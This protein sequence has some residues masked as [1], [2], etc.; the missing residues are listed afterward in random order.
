VSDEIQMMR[1]IITEA[2]NSLYGSKGFFMTLDGEKPPHKYHLAEAIEKLKAQANREYNRA[3][4]LREALEP[5]ARA[6]ELFT[7]PPTDF[8]QC[9][10]APAAGNRYALSGNDL[11][12][13]RE[14]MAY[15]QAEATK[16]E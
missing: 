14:A 16:S 1:A 10:Y 5:F 9:I 4:R 2:N 13:A 11:R 15:P 8:D 7:G 3:E 6:G 12:K